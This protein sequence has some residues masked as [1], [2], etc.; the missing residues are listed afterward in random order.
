MAA[1]DRREFLGICGSAAASRLFTAPRDFPPVR[2]IT[3][4]PRHHWFGYYDKLQFDPTDRFAL[5][6]QIDFEHRHRGPT[7]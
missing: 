1:F 5:G 3:R 7:T 6:N 2:A 4:G